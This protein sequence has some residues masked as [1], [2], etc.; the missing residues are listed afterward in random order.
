MV[1]SCWLSW[2]VWTRAAGAHRENGLSHDY[3]C[4]GIMMLSFYTRYA[5]GIERERENGP[6]STLHDFTFSHFSSSHVN[7]AHSLYFPSRPVGYQATIMN[8]A[9]KMF[10]RPIIL[11][12]SVTHLPTVWSSFGPC[13]FLSVNAQA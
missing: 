10:P 8:T 13:C 9:G 2:T 3:N 1:L 11:S 5:R 6:C 7:L 4:S 12:Q